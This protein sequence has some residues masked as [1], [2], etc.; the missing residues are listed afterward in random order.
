M[1]YSEFE[2]A[3]IVKG[4]EILLM[5]TGLKSSLMEIFIF[6]PVSRLIEI[7]NPLFFNKL[8]HPDCRS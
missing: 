4:G 3:I 7:E 1:K 2:F 8:K 5:L 6:P